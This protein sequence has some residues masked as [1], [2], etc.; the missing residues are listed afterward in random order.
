[1]G[2]LTFIVIKI[3]IIFL[4]IIINARRMRTS[5]TVVCLFVCLCVCVSDCSRYTGYL[6]TVY[7]I[8]NIP[9]GFSLYSKGFQLS[10]FSEMVL[11]KTYS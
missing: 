2:F 8:L 4:I 9:A 1:M 3:I 6:R 5:V 11:F 10:D 7:N